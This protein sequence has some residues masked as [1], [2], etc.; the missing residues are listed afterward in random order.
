MTD[1]KNHVMQK[2]QEARKIMNPQYTA[3]IDDIVE[4]IQNSKDSGD[5]FRIACN[6]FNFGYYQGVMAERAKDG[7]SNG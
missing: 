6:S 7:E 3:S 5:G 2:V 4:I 1:K